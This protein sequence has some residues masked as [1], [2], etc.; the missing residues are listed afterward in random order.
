M[1]L[2]LFKQ[3]WRKK[4][5][6]PFKNYSIAKGQILR[7]FSQGKLQLKTILVLYKK[8]KIV[9]KKVNVKYLHRTF[10]LTTLYSSAEVDESL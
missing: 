4:T 2:R 7:F 9:L 1:Y 5:Q 10:P 6:I 3:Y 8:S